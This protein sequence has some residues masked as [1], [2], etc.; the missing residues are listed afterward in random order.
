MVTSDAAVIGRVRGGDPNAFS[1]L[2]D[3]YHER[4]AR[5]AMR[6]LGDSDDAADAV[7][8]AFIRAY[9]SLDR[10]QERDRFSSWLMCIVA[11]RCRS[12]TETSRRRAD[13]AGEWWQAHAEPE[14]SCGETFSGAMTLER[15]H[16]LTERLSVALS[17]LRPETRTAVVWKYAEDMSYEEMAAA[18]GV[19][20][21]ALKM[22][23]AR[24]SA[25]LRRVLAGAGVAVITVAII[26]A[27]HRPRDV[28]TSPV[29]TVS[30]V[31]C[32]TLRS[33]MRDTLSQGVRDTL[34]P[35]ARCTPDSS[36]LEPRRTR[37]R[38]ARI[39]EIF[40]KRGL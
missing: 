13:V 17:Q 29:T 38:P 23:V 19:G 1:L 39:L 3:R 40:Q 34:L 18:T 7:Q 26:F 9:N 2:V 8:D 36:A 5:L 31:A 20:I 28:E 33:L 24:G 14:R 37:T 16:A 22:R 15:D 27:A 12:A 6:L 4:C 21:S 25:Q 35:A 10:Y 11:N 30:T 32:D